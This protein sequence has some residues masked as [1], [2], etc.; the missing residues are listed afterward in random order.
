ME[1]VFD[2]SVLGLTGSSPL[3]GVGGVGSAL[4]TP[5]SQEGG[6]NKVKKILVRK[7][8]KWTEETRY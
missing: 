5:L 2:D 4:S 3:T 6:A 1:E 8:Y 7:K